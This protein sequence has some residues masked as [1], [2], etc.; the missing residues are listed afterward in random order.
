MGKNNNQC[1]GAYSALEIVNGKWKPK[2]LFQLSQTESL[3]FYELRKVIPDVT[4]KM[5][6]S[7][8]R[9]LERNNIV[10]RKIYAE[11]PPRVEYSL[12]EHG[13][14]IVPILDSLQEWGMKHLERLND[15]TT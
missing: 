14:S 3:R 12:T 8:L 11:V 13:R 9:E 7:H 5:L 2:V 4:Q 1:K 15:K 6:T 10:H